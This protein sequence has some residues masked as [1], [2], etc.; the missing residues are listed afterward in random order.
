MAFLEVRECR[1]G[2]TPVDFGR[3]ILEGFIIPILALARL[4][5]VLSRRII[6]E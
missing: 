5:M 3:A 6:Y 2:S 1:G 4:E